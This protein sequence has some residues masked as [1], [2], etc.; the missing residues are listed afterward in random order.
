MND[1]PI[2]REC[3]VG[4]CGNCGDEDAPAGC[5]RRTPE[6][7]AKQANRDGNNRYWAPSECWSRVAKHPQSFTDI[8]KWHYP[9]THGS[10][11]YRQELMVREVHAY[12][13]RASSLRG[14][15]PRYREE[16]EKSLGLKPGGGRIFGDLFYQSP[17]FAFIPKDSSLRSGT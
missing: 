3:V 14:T 2:C 8:L 12:E 15:K 10:G 5:L 9:M 13:V 4:Y 1:C 7:Q 6:A 17:L 16:V 11:D